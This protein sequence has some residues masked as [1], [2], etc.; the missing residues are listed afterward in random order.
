MLPVGGL[1]KYHI[2]IIEVPIRLQN[3]QIIV[4]CE[5]ELRLPQVLEVLGL[6]QVLGFATS[7]RICHKC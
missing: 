3:I 6:P 5:I 1:T 2:P 7:V 4:R